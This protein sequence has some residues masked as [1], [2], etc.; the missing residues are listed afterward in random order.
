M[1][2][3]G[4]YAELCAPIHCHEHNNIIIIYLYYKRETIVVVTGKCVRA[5]IQQPA[6]APRR[7]RARSHL[8]A[9]RNFDSLLHTAR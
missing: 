8:Y 3:N 9:Q 1:R 6:V 2:T 7:R 4:I 5:R